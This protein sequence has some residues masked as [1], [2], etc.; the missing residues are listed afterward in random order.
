MFLMSNM[1]NGENLIKKFQG[2]H[3][4]SRNIQT[5]LKWKFRVSFYGKFWQFGTPTLELA[6]FKMKHHFKNLPGPKES[7]HSKLQNHGKNFP[8]GLKLREIWS[9]KV[10][11]L[12][13]I[14]GPA[15][16]GM[17]SQRAVIWSNTWCSCCVNVH[18][19]IT[20]S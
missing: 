15:R 12:Q 17:T 2:I 16:Q 7:M 14:F 6:F 20:P 10:E 19:Q 3:Q 13:G 8:F 5:Y 4:K 9:F 18:D 1:F 11:T